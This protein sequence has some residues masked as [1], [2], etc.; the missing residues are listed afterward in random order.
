MAAFGSRAET[1]HK[2]N[3]REV[4]YPEEEYGQEASFLADEA[5]YGPALCPNLDVLLTSI[6]A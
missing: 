3:D 4:N 5:G 2:L 6:Q 1:S